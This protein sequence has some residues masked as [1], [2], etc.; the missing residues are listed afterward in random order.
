MLARIAGTTLIRHPD[1]VLDDVVPAARPTSSLR[2]RLRSVGF[3]VAGV[4]VTLTVAF[5]GLY[6]GAFASFLTSVCN[7]SP[8]VVAT[9]RRT[10]EAIFLCIGFGIAAAPGL[11][12]MLAR[13]QHRV[14]VPWVV[15]S[16]VLII[17]TLIVTLT[18]KP[19]R[20]CLF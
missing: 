3:H 2:P 5:I 14:A 11:W 8:A 1:T 7:D 10:L 17:A 20:W 12:A 6:V 13:R 18:A 4:A 19:T 9:H 16:G 15:A